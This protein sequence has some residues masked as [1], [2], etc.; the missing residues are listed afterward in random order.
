LQVLHTLPTNVQAICITGRRSASASIRLA[1]APAALPDRLSCRFAGSRDPRAS[2]TLPGSRRRRTRLV[3]PAGCAQYTAKSAF[4]PSLLRRVYFTCEAG[5]VPGTAHGCSSLARSPALCRGRGLRPPALSTPC[6]GFYFTCEARKVPGIA[7]GC[8]SLARSPALCRGR[9]LRPL[10]SSTPCTG[11]YFTCEASHVPGTAHRWSR[12]AR[13]PALCRGRGLRP[14]ASSTPCA[15]VYFTCEARNVP[16]AAHGCSSLA[17]SP[18]LCR[19]RG[20]RPNL[21]YALRRGLLHL[22]GAG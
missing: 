3:R 9:G 2:L 11:I 15:G 20:L 14:L 6:A 13:S 19:G 8:S 10:A 5:N 12:L 4:A 7:H 1:S 22:R 21:K 18:A 16:G 17:R